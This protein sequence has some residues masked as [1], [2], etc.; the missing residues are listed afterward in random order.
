MTLNTCK[1][2]KRLY[3]TESHNDRTWHREPWGCEEHEPNR[4][5]ELE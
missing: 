1:K 5:A 2:C 4:G 3:D